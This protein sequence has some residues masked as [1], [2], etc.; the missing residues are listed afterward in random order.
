MDGNKLQLSPTGLCL[1]EDV[2]SSTAPQMH[3]PTIQLRALQ[4]AHSL[5]G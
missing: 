3:K 1:S 5:T 2:R 4:A